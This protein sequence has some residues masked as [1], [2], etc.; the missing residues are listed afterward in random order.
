MDSIRNSATVQQI[1]NG[2]VADKA[3]TEVN[4]TKNEF[5][6]LANSRQTP[7]TTT[8]DGQD[9]TH[10]H[11]L[12]YNLLSWE[13]PRATAVS[14]TTIV[15]FVFAFRYVPVA[16]YLLRVMYLLLGATA[17]AEIVGK[18]ALGEGFASKM[19]P[20]RYYTI[21]HETL[22]SI[23][24]DAEEL[25]NFFVIE[26]QRMV[27]AENV[28]V[29]IGA[30]VSAFITYY[31]V[32]IMPTW[33]LILFFTTL[34][35][36]LPLAYLSNKEFIDEH[37]NNAQTIVS[38]QATQV[39][40]LAAHH[41]NNA[42]QASHSAIK[43]AS[44]KAQEMIGQSKKAAVE[45][46]IISPETAEQVT[47]EKATLNGQS[48]AGALNNNGQSSNITSQSFPTAPTGEPTI[49]ATLTANIDEQKTALPS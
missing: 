12:F 30:F 32:K 1:T 24:N 44:S 40:D 2:P 39:W 17:V 45:K 47:P 38:E 15:L 11:S 29:T 16:R 33:G 18:I 6:N 41:T 22:Q 37:I 27:F 28:F 21:P 36:F 42:M 3:R 20:K 48:S 25:I 4:A 13:N 35:Y 8:A 5:T 14:Y 7:Q 34:I 23:L 31:L 19:R 9:L 43:D 10:Y 26:F 46:G 49:P